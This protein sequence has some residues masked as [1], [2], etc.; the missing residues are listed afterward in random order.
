MKSK[1]F[2]GTDHAG[3][4]LKEAVKEFLIKEGYDVE[5]CGALEYDEKD[6]YPAFIHK[7]A[8]RVSEIKG[9]FGVVFGGSG[10]GEAIVANKVKGIRAALYYGLDKDIL[11]LS[12]THNDANI[13]SLGARFLKKEVAVEAVKLWLKTSFTGEERHKRRIDQ[14]KDLEE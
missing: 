6:D 2:L 5:D 11:T 10:Q 14:I 3:F 8:S 13:L 9:S 7:A 12:K 4:E 1:I